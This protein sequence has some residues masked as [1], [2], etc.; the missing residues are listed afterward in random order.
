MI[1]RSSVAL[2]ILLGLSMYILS[3]ALA[4]VSA[5]SVAQAPANPDSITSKSEDLFKVFA[6]AEPL[7]SSQYEIKE[8]QKIFPDFQHQPYELAGFNAVMLPFSYFD[9]HH[10]GD[11]RE[12][13]ALNEL[14]SYDLDW[15]PGCYCSRHAFYVFQHDRIRILALQQKYAPEWISSLVKYWRATHAIGGELTRTADGYEGKLE[16]FS[17]DGKPVFTHSYDQPRSFWDLLGDM[18]VDAMTFLDVKPSDELIDYLHQPRCKQ[19]HSLI[20]LGSTAFMTERSPGAFDVY[21]QIL[22]ADPVFAIVRHW[23]A[24]QKFLRDRDYRLEALQEGLALSSRL[25]AGALEGFIPKY[26]PDS[27]LAEQY[28]YWLDAAAQLVSEDS[29]VIIECRLGKGYRGSQNLQSIVNRGLRAAAKYPNS[30]YMVKDV[31]LNADDAWMSASLYTSSLLDRY[32]PGFSDKA[33]AQ[34]NLAQFCSMAGRDDIAM[35]LLSGEDPRQPKT[36]LYLLLESLTRAGQF[37]QATGFY[38]LLGPTFVP[39]ASKWMAPNA[40]FAAVV[41]GDAPLLDQILK[42]QHDVLALENLDDVFQAYRDAMSGKTIDPLPFLG[43]GRNLNSPSMWKMLLIASCDA[44]QGASRYH[45]Q[46]TQCFYDA[47]V[48]RLIWIA[49]DDYQRRNPSNDASEIYDYLGWFF[50]DDPWV[51]KAVADFHQRRG[52]E[53]AVNPSMLRVDLQQALRDGPYYLHP[54]KVNWNHMLTPWRVAACVHELLKQNEIDDAAKIA[55][56]YR[57]FESMGTYNTSRRNVACELVHKVSLWK[58]PS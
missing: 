56:T 38:K 51:V 46:M 16:I 43:S 57:R 28:P 24:N 48:N 47:P 49:E 26:C 21:A 20:D 40:A 45:H 25:E 1:L 54:D 35:E 19:S 58:A 44:K 4:P 11:S 52:A 33:T 9:P 37:A 29:P 18:D 30:H 39:T 34:V 5:D 50:G 27:E 15:S 53:K 12:A 2:R 13:F 36:N 41:T 22:K 7:Q 42:D 3:V 31:A 23:Y 14:I 10:L 55:K 32:L 6:N 17:S 8:L